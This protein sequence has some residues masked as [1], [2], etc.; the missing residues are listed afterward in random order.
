VSEPK[1]CPLKRNV[2]YVID[3]RVVELGLCD[4]E[5]CEWYM[6]EHKESTV[7]S[8]GELHTHLIAGHCVIHDIGRGR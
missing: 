3:N 6:E 2:P 1:L 8:T 4:Q 7:S 5:R